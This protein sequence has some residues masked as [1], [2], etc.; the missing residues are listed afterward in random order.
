MLNSEEMKGISGSTE[1][2]HW[3]AIYTRHQHEGV[4]AQNLLG[5]GFEVFLP[6][7]RA[8]HR[9]KDRQKKLLLPLFPSYVFIRGGLDRMLNIV[10]TP[11][12][13]SLVSWGGRPANIPPEEIDGVRRLIESHLQVEPH[14]FLKCGDRVRIKSGPLEGI[15][16]IL[17]RKTRG[18]RLV[19]SVEMLSKS[20]AVEVDVGIV[21]VVHPAEADRDAKPRIVPAVSVPLPE[22]SYLIR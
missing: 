22:R 13:H 12:V 7:Y 11:G 5:K 17:V 3:H 4:V 2:G 10:T 14:P 20:A 19:L 18:Y 6:Q 16:G 21:E 9:W 8:V 1:S 15:E